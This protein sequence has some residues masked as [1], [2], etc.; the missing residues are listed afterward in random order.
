MSLSF[1][2]GNGIGYTVKSENITFTIGG[3][4]VNSGVLVPPVEASKILAGKS[5]GTALE[6]I[7]VPGGGDMLKSI[8]DADDDG[9]IDNVDGGVFHL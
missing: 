9:L 6:Y 5:D 2:V 7:S 1:K 3:V 8:Y 4:Q